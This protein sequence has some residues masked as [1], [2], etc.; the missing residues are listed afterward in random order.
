M[1]ATRRTDAVIRAFLEEGITELPDRTFDAVRSDIHRTRQRVVLGPWEEPNM[2]GLA[3]MAV[4][5]AIVLVVGAVAWANLGPRNPGFGDPGP[6]PTLVPTLPYT[7]AVVSPGTWR[8]PYGTSPGVAP[9]ATPEPQN[10]GIVV[11]VPAGW[12]SFSGFALDKNYGPTDADA[13][14]SFVVWAIIDTF[15]DPCTDHSLVEPAPGPG[16]DDLIAAL[17]AMPGVSAAAPS[18]VTIDGFSGKSIDLTVTTN[19]DTCPEGFWTWGNDGDYRY[20]QVNGEVD[21]VYALDVNGHRRTFF[22]R[23]PPRT[24]TVDRAE[25]QSIV[26]SIDIQP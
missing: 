20:A 16:V 1:T 19:L 25:L 4:A 14:P 5:A 23:I 7:G 17:A 24:T 18:D 13:G 22:L 11:T 15:R 12:T 3:R 21:R 9:S 2:S 26:D 6:T 8:I 10:P